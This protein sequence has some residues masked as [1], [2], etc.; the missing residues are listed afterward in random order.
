MQKVSRVISAWLLVCSLPA[1]ATGIGYWPWHAQLNGMVQDQGRALDLRNE[2]GMDSSASHGFLV[3]DGWLQLSYMP[4]NF[5]GI[6]QLS[7]DATFGGAT[8]SSNADV[9][10][11][12]DITDLGAR[13]LWFPMDRLGL[14]VTV[15]VLDGVVSIEEQGSGNNREEKTFSEA[16]PLLSAS[17]AAQ[18]LDLASLHLDVGYF[19]LEDNWALELGVG[20]EIA[21]DP[22]RV[23]LGWHEKQYDLSDGASGLDARAKG[24]FGQIVFML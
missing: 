15:K 2:L 23:R 5:A 22:I 6:G 11:Q 7:S 24:L 18:L 17:Y 8:F 12:A 4:M 16:F 10:S 21:A 19:A 1:A 9:Y 20:V 13:F 14:G 3:D